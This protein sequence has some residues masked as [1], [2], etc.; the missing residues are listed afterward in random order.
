MNEF[1]LD[2]ETLNFTLISEGPLNCP[3][4][5]KGIKPIAAADFRKDY[6][7][8]YEIKDNIQPSKFE[9][10]GE[11]LKT[12]RADGYEEILVDSEK[13]GDPFESYTPEEIESLLMFISQRVK[14]MEK[15]EFGKNLEVSRYLKG[16]GLFDMIVLDIPNH[17]KGKCME[18]AEI[19]NAGV[20][21]IYRNEHVIA[22][23]PFAP[24]DG[25]EF[26]ITPL[27]H[28][29]ITDLDQVLAFDIA[30]VIK[31]FTRFAGGDTTISVHQPGNSHFSIRFYQGE[32][33]PFEILGIEK[34][35]YYPESLAK[36]AGEKLKDGTKH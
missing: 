14:S 5:K 18:C 2:P 19:S 17:D 36:E 16:H 11:F 23:V 24:R 15:Y 13:H 33:N 28:I 21:E 6:I 1:R 10:S 35:D 30:A 22:Y 4:C 8:A 31:K 34:I 26:A 7:R 20:R 9:L 25:F 12:S 3:A 29:S 32:R 27:K